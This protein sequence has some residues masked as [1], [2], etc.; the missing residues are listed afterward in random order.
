MNWFAC[1]LWLEVERLEL[2]TN[3]PLSSIPI[4]D[5]NQLDSVNLTTGKGQTCQMVHHNEPKGKVKNHQR[6]HSIGSG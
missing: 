3:Q 1:S 6:R 2:T 5:G 4:R